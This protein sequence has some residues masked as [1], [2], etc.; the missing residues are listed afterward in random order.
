MPSTATGRER[1]RTVT[2]SPP[3]SGIPFPGAQ[4][5]APASSNRLT[6]ANRPVP[7]K[8]GPNGALAA[9]SA[10]LLPP[11]VDSVVVE[12]RGSR[13]SFSEAPPSTREKDS[14]HFDYGATVNALTL[15]FLSEHEETRVAA[16]EWLLMLHQ[17]APQRVCLPFSLAAAAIAGIGLTLESLVQI[18]A[19]D[20]PS[21]D[22]SSRSQSRVRAHHDGSESGLSIALLLKM[23]SDP[24]EK[25][26]RGDLRLLSQILYNSEDEYFPSFMMSLLSLFST[27]RRLLETRGSLI[28]RELCLSLNTERIYRTFAEILEKDEVRGSSFPSLPRRINSLSAPGSRV[29]FHHGAEPQP[30]HDH[31]SRTGRLPQ[32]ATNTRV[33]GQRLPRVGR[34]AVG[35]T[36]F[37]PSSQDGQALFTILY[38]SWSH[39][40]IATFSLCL[41]A[42][43]YEQAYSLLQIL[44]VL[45]AFGCSCSTS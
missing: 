6:S 27:D 22:A 21:G 35:L 14:P 34:R 28:I 5:P 19:I 7:W 23:L 41:L 29:C 10:P 33:Q 26:L 17:K 8:P 13:S 25:V 31:V 30:Y 4:Q 2:N 15:Q 37:C 40:A 16:L 36:D 39:N 9:I 44:C 43:A 1:E 12:G 24:S 38:R 45:R 32:T 20:E 11:V 42:Q 3:P 18:L